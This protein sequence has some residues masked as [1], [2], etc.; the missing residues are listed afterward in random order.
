M[1]QT[2]ALCPICWPYVHS[3]M[4]SFTDHL[5]WASAGPGPAGTV[6]PGTGRLRPSGSSQSGAVDAYITTNDQCH[7]GK[8]PSQL[9]SPLKYS[10]Y[11]QARE[12]NLFLVRDG[13]GSG[14]RP[15]FK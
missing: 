1:V 2:V 6:V 10:H 8:E 3:L 11:P 13:F 4:H 14:L 9:P 12:N 5:A 15:L 7:E